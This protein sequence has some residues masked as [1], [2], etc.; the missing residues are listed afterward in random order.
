[1]ATCAEVSV[2]RKSGDVKVV[3][4]VA[5]FEC[6]AIVN[7]DGLR[8]Q[9]V[10]ANIMGLGGALFEAIEF[11][12][13]RILNGRFSKYRLPRFSDV[14]AIEVVLLDRKDIPSAGAGEAP[15]EGVAPAIG[16]AIFDA[17]GVRL[18]SMP[19]VPNGLKT[20]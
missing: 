17:T 7:P 5:A 11:E 13:G 20:A 19:L 9:V 10:G 3:R 18:R 1:L 2:D 16:N 8:N 15:I 14:P 12:N 6:G 4:M